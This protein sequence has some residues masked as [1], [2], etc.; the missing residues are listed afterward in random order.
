M[1]IIQSMRGCLWIILVVWLYLSGCSSDRPHVGD[2]YQRQQGKS[3][4]IRIKYLGTGDEIRND[5]K[6]MGY[7]YINGADEFRDD[8]CF[9]YEDSSL[10]LWERIHFL[11]IEP[12]SFLGTQYKKVPDPR[13]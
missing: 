12:Q 6:N 9:A 11:K 3:Q 5:A 8:N 7:R 1:K 2:W 10:V 4:I 13:K